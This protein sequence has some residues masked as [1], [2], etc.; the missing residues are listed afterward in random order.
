MSIFDTHFFIIII[1]ASDK[2]LWAPYYA[3]ADG[4]CSQKFPF[5]VLDSVPGKV[6]FRQSN[7]SGRQIGV[8]DC[9][10]DSFLR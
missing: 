7:K 9:T 5:Q 2:D 1:L 4:T 8:H 10:L 3:L 6:C